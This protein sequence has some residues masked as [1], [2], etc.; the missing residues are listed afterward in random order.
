MEVE[1]TSL[2]G[3]LVIT[4]KRFGDDRG[5]FSETWSQRNLEAVIP[6]V[7]FVQDNESLSATPGTVRGLHYQA[8][9][10][11]QAK[12]LRVLSGAIMDVAV[13]ARKGSP[14]Y[15]KWVAVELSSANGKQLY[16]PTGFLH[17][18]ATLTPDTLIAYKCSDYYA[19][20]ADGTVRFDSCGVDWG[21]DLSGAVLSGKDEAAPT[22][23]DWNSPFTFGGDA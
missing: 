3:V 18:F 9:P 21:M 1:Q 20:E 14:H 22:F 2:P 15:G 7:N 5:Y 17:G 12:L 19:P 6:G 16:I 11:A 13:D 8:P 10:H 23:S 4:P